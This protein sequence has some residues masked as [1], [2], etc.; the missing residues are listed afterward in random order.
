MFDAHLVPSDRLPAPALTPMRWPPPGLEPIQGSAWRALALL[1]AG[2][3]ITTTPL[4]LSVATPQD[5]WSSGLFGANW[6]IPVAAALVGLSLIVMALARCARI[7]LEGAN[8][9]RQGHDW[10]TVAHVACDRRYDAGFLLQGHRQYAALEERERRMLLNAR[11]TAVCSYTLGLLWTV[12]AFS[13]GVVLAGRNM[14]ASG[15]ALTLL[16]LGP[17]ALLLGMGAL[18]HGMESNACRA[19]ARTWRKD[20]TRERRLV[21]EIGDW[22]ADRSTRLIHLP[23]PSRRTLA[24]RM[25]A[26]VLIAVC[27][28]LPLPVIT[29]AVASAM[30]PVLA[31]VAIPRYDTSAARFARSALLHAY[32]LPAT[33]T[34]TALEAGESLHAIASI[35]RGAVQNPIE[36]EPVRRF[37]PWPAVEPPATLPDLQAFGTQLMPRATSLTPDEVAYLERI[38]SHPAHAEISRLARAP[39]IDVTGGRWH[40]EMFGGSSM[41]DLPSARFTGLREASQRHIARAVLELNRGQTAAAETTLREVISLGLLIAR[42]SPTMMDLLVGNSVAATGAAALQTFYQITGRNGDA[43]AMRRQAEGIEKAEEFARALHTEGDIDGGLRRAMAIAGNESLPR[44]VRWESLLAIQIGAGCL[45]PHTVVFG[46]G[47]EYGEW[48]ERTRASL[49]RYPTEQALFDLTLRGTMLPDYLRPRSN[50]I[51]RVLGLTIGRTE[52]AGA[53]AALLTGLSS[54]Q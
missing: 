25:G 48:L 7:L 46:H 24:A 1:A 13:A 54:M 44:G 2:A 42:E 27:V 34:M 30:G 32:A 3:A 47:T 50:I 20:E 14:V 18:A 53:C 10:S 4:L 45:N 6:W 43:D 21:D 51:A 19:V 33:G 16:V 31:Q 29:L 11:V 9:V 23:S 5:F 38:T 22:R 41:F 37:A 12:G 40:A 26:G 52:T 36:R 8:G 49:V 35:G 39:L 17:G 28:L 15:G